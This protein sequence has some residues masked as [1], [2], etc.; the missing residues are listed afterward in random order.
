MDKSNT[1]ILIVGAGV[2]G[3]IYAVKL[4]KVG[5]S[6]TMYARSRRLDELQE[7]GLVFQNTN[8]NRVE[9]AD[10]KIISTLSDEDFYDFI[11][12][13]VRYEQIEAALSDIKSNCSQNIITLVNNPF[14]Y[15]KWEGIVGKGRIIPAFPGAGGKIE[16]GVLCYKITTRL[17][18]STT[19]GELSSGRS[20]RVMRLYKL[21]K[22][23]DFPVSI[24]NDMDAWQKSHLAMVIPMANSIYFDG[25]NNYTT[26]QNKE[27]IHNMSLSL[28]ENFVFLK[29]SGIAV[30][31]FKLNV[32]R[33]CPVWILNIILKQLYRT[34]F[35]EILISNHAL[36]A[37]QEM[38]LLSN[39]FAELARSKGFYLRYLKKQSHSL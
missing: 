33:F 10:V 13:T 34:K 25:G 20:P 3:S 4:S 26:A 21:L 29:A 12:V 2:I 1:K 14:G 27:A 24:C 18:Q 11:F 6:V 19:I 15:D 30:T 31:P 38:G 23:S 16:S 7:N 22:S 37:K 28:K 36:N 8:T 17:V 39:E 32:F 5:Y 9:K 35:S